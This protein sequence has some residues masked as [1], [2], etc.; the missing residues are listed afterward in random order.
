MSR[1]ASDYFLG[2]SLL[3]FKIN[4]NYPIF[5]LFTPTWRLEPAR[6]GQLNKSDFAKGCI[7]Y[8]NLKEP[9]YTLFPEYSDGY[10]AIERLI[11]PISQ[12]E[13]CFN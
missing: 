4:P 7:D 8:L 9:Q 11:F 10:K 12:S 13:Y 5:L 6:F 1:K 2:Q 3:E